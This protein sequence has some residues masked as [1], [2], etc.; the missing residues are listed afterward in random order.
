MME[1]TFDTPAWVLTLEALRPG[2]N[3]S[4]VRFLALMEQESEEDFE[5]ALE[6]LRQRD[7]LLDAAELPRLT[8]A[9]ELALQLKRE[10]QL[11]KEGNLPAGLEENDPLRL[12]LE[13]LAAIPVCGDPQLL[14]QKSAVGDEKARQQLVNLMLS[15]VVERSCRWAG[16]SVLLMDLI[17]EGSLALWQAVLE[18]REG[19][20]REYCCRFVDGAVAQVLVAQAREN[21][22]GQKMLEALEDYRTVDERLLADLGRNPTMEEIAQE[23]H[24]S[25]E[26]TEVV[27]QMLDAARTV[28]RAKA[29]TEKKEPT[30]EDQMAVEDTAYFQMRQ[31]ITE[32]LSSLEEEDR[33]LLT[34]RYGLEGGLP[35]TAEETGRKL[36]LTA[37]QVVTREAAALSKLRKNEMR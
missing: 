19:D 12:Y 2:A 30:A 14:A 31:R 4:A 5:E 36:G 9:G 1:F 16:H 11:A 3:L 24:L 32:L 15:L 10:E 20:F 26:E 27:A 33:K 13:E 21:G 29:A 7:I 35:L 25:L 8:G 34:L 37:D 6:F 22:V 18:Y 23:L 17:Q 28:S